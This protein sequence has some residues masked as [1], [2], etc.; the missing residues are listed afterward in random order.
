MSL[1]HQA[2][3]AQAGCSGQ[4][5]REIEV[6]KLYHQTWSVALHQQHSGGSSFFR[7]AKSKAHWEKKG[8][9][10]FKRAFSIS[11]FL[12]TCLAEEKECE[13]SFFNLSPLLG[14]SLTHSRGEEHIK[15][16]SSLGRGPQFNGKNGSKIGLKIGLKTSFWVENWVQADF[17]A[18]FRAVFYSIELG[19]CAVI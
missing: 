15:G 6:N 13:L 5:N 7:F 17:W 12:E 2:P 19:P 4:L 11:P 10:Q 9:F 14:I 18:D 8:E 1:E 3:Q 16:K